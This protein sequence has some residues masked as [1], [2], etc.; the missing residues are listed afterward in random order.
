MSGREL[1]DIDVKWWRNQIGLVQQDNA[2]FTTSI[3]KNVEFGLIG[4]VWENAD[5]GTKDRLVRDACREASADEFISRLPEVRIYPS[6]LFW[7][8]NLPV[9]APGTDNLGA[10]GVPNCSRRARYQAERGSTPA[11]CHCSR[12]R[13]AA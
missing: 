2:L 3:Y 10:I 1:R 9:L 11:P 5:S 13:E 8:W 4:T 6:G 12:Y 7:P